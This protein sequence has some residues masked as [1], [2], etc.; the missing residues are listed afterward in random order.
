VI[1]RRAPARRP[2]RIAYGRLCQETNAFSP[3]LS[4]LEDFERM[5]LLEGAALHEATGPRGHEVPGLIKDAELSGFRRVAERLGPV[6]CVP[7]VSAWAMPSGPLTEEACAELRR[8]MVAALRAA[9]PVDGVLLA[10]HG[11]MRARGAEPDPEA[12]L[13]REVRAVVGPDVPVVATFDLHGCLTAE[14]VGHLTS[15]QAYRTNPH[16]DL[17][18][19]GE[20]AAECLLRACRG[21]VVPTSAWRSLPMILGG[22]T[23]IDVLAPMRAVFRR[24]KAMERE[25]RVLAT[26]LFM[27]HPFN[28]SPDL[29]WSVHVTTDGDGPLAERLADELAELAWAKR[30]I[31]PPEFHP[32]EAAIELVRGSRLARALGTCCLVDVSDIVG[33]GSTGENTHLVR[34]L[35]EGAQGL[36]TYAPLRDPVAVAALWGQA[37]GAP[38]DLDVGGRLDP[39]TNPSLRIRGTLARTVDSPHW[40]KTAVVDCDHLQLVLT[41]RPP[42]PLKPSFYGDLGLSVWRADAVVVKNFFHYRWYYLAQCRRSVPVRTKGL[43]DLDLALTVKTTDPVFPRDPVADWRPTDRLRR[44]L[45]PRQPISAS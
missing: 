27:V 34:A 7:L 5:H 33:A 14:K 42:L 38:V 2:L 28:D 9:G 35:L 21:E 40:G 43:T 15:L 19:T 8:R 25:P 12:A 18:R 3:V 24:M 30:R 29:G 16:R 26:S 11:A 44:G 23:T 4:T 36:R 1:G 31:P 39:A 45:T 22:G 37:A 13:L 20:R 10:L 41:E 6:E 32:P 17:R